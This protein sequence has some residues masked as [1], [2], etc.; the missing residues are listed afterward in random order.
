MMQKSVRFDRK[1]QSSADAIPIGM[2]HRAFVL[3]GL[4][5]SSANGEAEKLVL[6]EKRPRDVREECFVR[7]PP[8]NVPFITA[9]KRGGGLIV[10]PDLICISPRNGA[11]TG[12]KLIGNV[13]RVCNPDIR[14][15]QR[16]ER[17]AKFG[18]VPR[19]RN[20]H[21]RRLSSRVNPGIRPTSSEQCNPTLEQ[22]FENVFDD[23][24]NRYRCRLTLPSG[25]P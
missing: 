17:S 10:R 25:E 9:P 13:V 6:A 16:V 19:L 14:G 4:G 5:G 24:L 22:A 23:T 12:V 3:V 7:Q 20:S 21:V 15:E 8:G 18:G 11:V 2:R 1:V